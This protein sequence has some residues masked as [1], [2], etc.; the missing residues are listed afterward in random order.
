MVATRLNGG[1]RVRFLLSGVICVCFWAAASSGASV[2]V[3]VPSYFYPGTGGPGGVGDGWAAMTAAA[4]QIPVIAVLNPNSGPGGSAD[5]NYAAAMTGLEAAG[6]KTVAYVFTNFGNTPIA[7][8]ESQVSTYI[9]QYGNLIDGFYLDGMY[10]APS[11]LSYYQSLDSYIK[12]LKPSYTVVG[13]PGQPYLNGVAPADYLS[14]ADIFDVFEGPESGSSSSFAN[15]PFGQTWYQGYAAG[16]FDN[17][18]FNAPGSDMAGDVGRAAGLGAGYVYVTDQTLPNPYAQLP[19]YWDQEVAAIGTL[20]EPC[21]VATLFLA[22]P[23]ALGR[24]RWRVAGGK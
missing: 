15:Y 22:A 19:S 13:N 17:T 18:I 21:A 23:I 9:S 24:R 16:R 1:K 4:A 3:I 14:T 20:P 5:A 10:D 11:T 7:T 6:G 12:G 2:G 8:V